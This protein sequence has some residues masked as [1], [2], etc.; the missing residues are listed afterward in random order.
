MVGAIL[1]RQAVLGDCL[2]NPQT[3]QTL[4]GLALK[5]FEDRRQRYYYGYLG[6][7][8]GGILS[9]AI[10][11]MDLLV[12]ILRKIRDIGSASA[13]RFES[14]GSP[15]IQHHREPPGLASVHTDDRRHRSFPLFSLR[16]ERMLQNLLT[17]F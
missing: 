12:E 15:P 16:N 7:Y 10:G 14:T 8:P 4:Y 5:A 11:L 6:R 1:H 9:G 17:I 2:R 3:V 13:K